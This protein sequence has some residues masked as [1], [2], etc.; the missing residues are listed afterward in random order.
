MAS[1]LKT[2][3]NNPNITNWSW[4]KGYKNQSNENDYP[5]HVTEFGVGS[6]LKISFATYKRDHIRQCNFYQPGLRLILTTPGE[7]TLMATFSMQIAPLEHV[8][9]PIEPVLTITSERLRSYTP[10]QR[11]C[12]FNNERRLRFFRTYTRYNCQFECLANQTKSICGCVRYAMPSIKLL[13]I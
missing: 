2:V 1:R 11:G 9:I 12:F 4:D 5:F 10:N 13:F 8:L 6:G 7:T 3:K